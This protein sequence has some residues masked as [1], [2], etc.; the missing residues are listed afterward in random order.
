MRSFIYCSLLVLFFLATALQMMGAAAEETYEP[1]PG[2]FAYEA[3]PKKDSPQGT[4]QLEAIEMLALEGAKVKSTFEQLQTFTPSE[5]SQKVPEGAFSRIAFAT[6]ELFDAV[7]DFLFEGGN[8]RLVVVFLFLILSGAGSIR[9][10]P[11][12]R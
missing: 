7:W 6:Q 2:S 3:L 1:A 12:R 10:L 8:L 4:Q 9:L 11:Q 5:T